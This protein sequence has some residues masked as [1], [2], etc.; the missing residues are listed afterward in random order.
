MFA[1][2]LRKDVLLEGIGAARMVKVTSP[3][4]TE[5]STV[6]RGWFGVFGGAMS[7]TRESQLRSHDLDT[8]LRVLD[9]PGAEIAVSRN[10][11]MG[12]ET[13]ISILAKRSRR[14]FKQR[15]EAKLLSA[16]ARHHCKERAAYLE[17]ELA[18]CEDDVLSRR[19]D[20]RLDARI[21]LIQET[22][23]LDE[24]RHLG[25]VLWLQRD[26][27]NRRRLRAR[28][29]QHQEPRDRGGKEKRNSR[30]W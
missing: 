25:R 19:L 13:V 21:G 24:F 11:T 5:P 15:C 28:Q 22:E 27:D 7:A 9:I 4:C 29:N 3:D 30:Y 2:A 16:R 18:C 10:G 17:M 26:A 20:E 6:P 12:G 1:L 23:T 14:S 8:L